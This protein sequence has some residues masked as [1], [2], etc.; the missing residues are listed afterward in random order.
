MIKFNKGEFVWFIILC[1]FS[2]YLGYLILTGRIHTYIHPSMVK[3]TILSLASFIALTLYQLR[4]VFMINRKNK[5][6]VGYLIFF[7]PLILGFTTTGFDSSIADK[8][9]VTLTNISQKVAAVSNGIGKEGG[10]YIVDGRVI[11]NELDY[12]KILSDIEKNLPKYKG[13]RV[14]IYGFVYKQDDF[15]KDKFVIA[16]MTMSCCAAD[17]QVV[18]LISKWDNAKTLNKGEWINIEGVIDTTM[19]KEP[20]TSKEIELPIIVVEKVEKIQAGSQYIY[21]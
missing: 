5:I 4:N 10:D 19:Y 18:G 17:A 2:M 12:Y 11:F 14:L 8:K 21:Q 15:N 6:N 3:Y 1:G 13:K 20:N 9:G 7:L 16:R